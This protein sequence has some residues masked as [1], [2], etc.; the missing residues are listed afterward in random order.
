MKKVV[1]FW[2]TGC[3]PCMQYAPIFDKVVTE[4]K[5]N[6]ELSFLNIDARNDDTGL[7][8]LLGIR[9]IPQ[10]FILDE[11]NNVLKQKTGLMD[12]NTLKSFILE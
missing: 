5:D 10:T 6:S 12:E 9:S 8:Q 11:D 3:M 2:G 4:L 1:K 7:T